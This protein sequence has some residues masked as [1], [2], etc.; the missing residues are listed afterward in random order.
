MLRGRLR[1]DTGAASEDSK[2]G[3][4]GK[5]GREKRLKVNA[6]ARSLIPIP[7]HPPTAV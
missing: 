4:V 2:D 5:N 3:S 7:P 6:G 1:A